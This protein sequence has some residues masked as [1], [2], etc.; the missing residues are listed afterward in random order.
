M[1]PGQARTS[2]LPFPYG[3]QSYYGVRSSVSLASNLLGSFCFIRSATRVAAAS[4]RVS[5]IAKIA[6]INFPYMLAF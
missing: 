6:K 2:D 5:G 3:V 1:L 4:C